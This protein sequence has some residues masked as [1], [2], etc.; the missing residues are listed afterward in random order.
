MSNRWTKEQEQALTIRNKDLLLSAAAGSGKTAVLTERITRL[1]TEGKNPLQVQD[2]LVLTFTKAAASEMRGRISASLAKALKKADEEGNE[3]L[4]TH[5]EKQIALLGSAQISTLD[6]FFQSLVKQYFYLLDLDLKTKIMADSNE[7]YLLKEEAIAEVLEEYYAKGDAAFLKVADLFQSRYQD[8]ELKR[9]VIQIYDF[10]RSMPF[11]THWIS[12][13]ADPYEVNAENLDE[14]PAA[15]PILER[16]LTKITQIAESYRQMFKVMELSPL[17]EKT[18]AEQLGEEFSYF[19][20]LSKTTSWNEFLSQ[21]MFTFATLKSPSKALLSEYNLKSSEFTASNEAKFIK[22]TRQDAKDLY[23]KEILPY[24]AVEEKQWLSEIRAMAPFVKVLANLTLS[25]TDVY[26]KKKKEEQVMEFDDLEHLTLD[27]LLDKENP[28]FS[29]DHAEDFP[30]PQALILQ[31]RYK[32][33]MI[34][35]YQDTNGVQELITSLLS[36]GHNRFMVGDIKQSIYRFRQADPTIFLSKYQDFEHPDESKQRIDLNKNFRSDGVLLDSI[37]Y[38]FKQIMTEKNLELPYGKAEALYPSRFEGEKPKDYVGGKVSLLLMDGKSVKESDDLDPKLKDT[39]N[40]VL[41]G[42]LIAQTIH[43]LVDGKK[44]VMEKD[45]TYRPITYND[46]VILLR[47]ISTKGPL[48]LRTLE[49]QGIPAVSD[50]EDDFVRN[51]E[52]AFL[53]ALLKLLD[54]PLQ[55]LPLTAILRSFLIELS[56]NDLALLYEKKKEIK[57]SYLW[58]VLKGDLSFLGAKEGAVLD[59][60]SLYKKWRKESLADG[61]APLLQTILEDTDY[62]PYVSGLPNGSVRKAHVISFYEMALERDTSSHNGLYQFLSFLKDLDKDQKEFR[63]ETHSVASSEAVRIMTIHR[64]KG[65]EFPVVFL[66]DSGKAFNLKDSKKTVILHKDL[67]LGI[68]YYDEEYRARWP[69][70]I[71]NNASDNI[72]RESKAEE[73][74]LLYVAMTRA[75]DKLYI[76]GSFPDAKKSMENY[77][78]PLPTERNGKLSS[79]IVANGS[80]Y[81][82]WMLPAILR[83]R[84]TESTWALLDKVPSYLESEEEGLSDFD[85][86]IIDKKELFT[87]EELSESD[88][89]FTEEKEETQKE[90]LPSVPIPEWFEK[91]ILWKYPHVGA[92]ETP[93]KLTATQAVELREKK[94]YALADAPPFPGALLVEDPIVSEEALP[95]DFPPFPENAN[96]SED[97]N[98]SG[99]IPLPNEEVRLPMEEKEEISSV[100]P[101]YAVIPDFMQEEEVKL[102]GGT[103]FGTLMHKAMEHIPFTQVSPTKAALTG[104]IEKLYQEGIFTEEERNILLS[105][106]HKRRPLWAL[107]AFGRGPLAEK[108]K[109]AKRIRKEMPF[110]ILLSAHDFYP[111]CEEGEKIFLQGVMDCLLEMEDGLIIIDYKTDRFMTEEE[112]AN[113]YKVQL[114]VYGEAAKAL[115]R[116]PVKGL[117]LWSL[118]L[119]KEIPIEPK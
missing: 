24:L 7:K 102:Q 30:S 106:T 6:S 56:S 23:K 55:D 104:E 39:K 85:I 78:K 96:P 41:E 64:S 2:L 67:G 60:L 42:R 118:A 3:A 54:N 75:R 108:M 29:Y 50:R 16:L 9:I 89:P 44:E 116:K 74:R 72:E 70:I 1:L 110:S 15:K 98:S 100:P 95:I 84:S 35:E 90:I 88:L 58:D 4:I 38:I 77:A 18:Y 81:F 91:Q 48:L 99:E 103:G 10:S 14:L 82:D 68:Q 97:F 107:I 66:S 114:Q 94:E 17:A 113:H 83:H 26:R 31:N 71:W 101:D 111:E 117:Y 22:S 62:L 86:S 47:S 53:W 20:L 36:N 59:F 37:N 92:T 63:S 40:I 73:A 93:A 32:E 79:Y 112:L 28:D 25:F 27:L 12:K 119:H 19:M 61:I 76:T 11:P 51:N 69:T 33:V 57:A 105:P 13:L 65:L 34:D 49:E 115:F 43:S 46:I 80:S 5:L 52:V 87:E 8:K 109:E 45:G 21:G